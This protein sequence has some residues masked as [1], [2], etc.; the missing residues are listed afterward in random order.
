M[1]TRLGTCASAVIA[2][3]IV[4]V[5][6]SGCQRLLPADVVIRGG[7]IATVDAAF[8]IREAVAVRDGTIVYVGDGSGLEPFL[9][10]QTRVIELKGALVLPGFVDAHAHMYSL[11]QELANL[12][13]TGTRS[14]QEIINR[15]AARVRTAKPGEWIVGGRWDQN[16]W[17]DTA[18]PVHDALSAVSPENPVYLKRV[19]G[20][21]AL[22]NARALEAA[23]ITNATPNPTGGVIHR[24]RNGE[25]AGVLVNRAMDLVEAVTPKDTPAQY[26]NKLL[27]AI[28]RVAS[29][30]LT[31]WHEAGVTPAEIAT[32]TGLVRRG[33][34]K[35]RCYAMLGDERNPE[36]TGDLVAYFRANRVEDDEHH[37]FAVR[38]VKLFFDG[39]L[40]S[41]GAAFY[42][43]YADDPRNTGLLRVSPEYVEKVARAALET[44]MQVGT[45]CI[46][47]RGNRLALEAYEKA[48][49]HNPIRD[50]RF[51]IEHAQFVEPR[52]VAKF[53]ELGVLPAMQ[54]THATSDMPFVEARVGPERARGGYAW[55]DF[56]NAGLIIPSGS[57][58]PVE[59]P[60]PLL[61]IYAAVTRE[62]VDGRP[63]GGWYPGQ[64]MTIEEAIRGFTIWAATAAFREKVL[65]SIE[66]GKLADFT[67]LDK[68]ILALPPR[69]I[70]TARVLYTIVAGRVI[71]EAGS[72]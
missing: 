29:L 70:P 33:A 41:R 55:R 52:D 21:A 49:R 36:Y 5:V 62:D 16:D 69:Q 7:R 47:V 9:G 57:D 22:A 15:V 18:F 38:S 58:F 23:G 20:N 30:G 14:F 51:R 44:G 24:T 64:R 63:E 65:G 67:I 1:N 32:Y 40:G 3:S 45:H 46:G 39:A 50:H 43:P 17:A 54:P 34:L 4:G 25:P 59:S 53:A 8:S 61:G 66:V 13:V 35:L 37:M 68:D 10:P 12:D 48:L 60:N 72:R 2:T 56:L 42:E 28:D 6:V 19:D 11:G 27:G 71:Y 26:E 31:G